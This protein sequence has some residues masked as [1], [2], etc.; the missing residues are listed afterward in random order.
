MAV[1]VPSVLFG[2]FHLTQL[3]QGMPPSEN[4]LQIVN[5]IIFGILYAA[6]R[7]RV[8]N[9][10]PLIAFHILFDVFAAFSGLF[11]PAAVRGLSDIPRVMWGAIRIPS[12]AVAIYLLVRKPM[13]ATIDGRVAE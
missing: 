7:L 4:L 2:V 5:A 12:L 3:I 13:T 10:W 8:N 1:L 9:I 6:L 11:G